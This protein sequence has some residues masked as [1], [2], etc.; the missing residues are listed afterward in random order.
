MSGCVL[1]ETILE[2]R[3]TWPPRLAAGIG[4]QLHTAGIIREEVNPLPTWVGQLGQHGVQ[5]QRIRCKHGLSSAIHQR[6]CP[7][8]MYVFYRPCCGSNS[9]SLEYRMLGCCGASCFL[10]QHVVSAASRHLVA[11]ACG[12]GKQS[13]AAVRLSCSCGRPPC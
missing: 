11:S 2:L 9:E 1:Q 7:E 8:Y 13:I 12:R 5:G 4:L 6:S 10:E 3:D